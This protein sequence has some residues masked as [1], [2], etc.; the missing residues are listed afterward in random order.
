[1]TELDP[2]RSAWQA[3]PLAILT[4]DARG[5]VSSGNPA[6]ARLFAR[7]L[8]SMEQRPLDTWVHALDRGA[9]R[10]MISEAL[11]GRVPPRQEIRFHRPE[12]VVVVTGFSVAPAT[13]GGGGVCILRDLS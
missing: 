5:F 11:E 13:Q 2:Y 9:L 10:Q 8:A 6:S 1:M 3:S 7:D 4:L 12:N